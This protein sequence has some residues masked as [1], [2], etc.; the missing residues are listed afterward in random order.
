MVM[1][2]SSKNKDRCVPG[3]ISSSF[4]NDVLILLSFFY[5]GDKIS[6]FCFPF[7]LKIMIAFSF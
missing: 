1:T 5:W 2:K 3:H 7:E 4:E 6:G